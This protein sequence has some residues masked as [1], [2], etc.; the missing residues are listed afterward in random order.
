MDWH[1]NQEEKQRVKL[2]Q[3]L[4]ETPLENSLWSMKDQ[5]YKGKGLTTIETT[6]QI[7]RFACE[8]LGLSL[9]PSPLYPLVGNSDF[10]PG[11]TDDRFRLLKERGLG[12]VTKFIIDGEW[13]RF[14]SLFKDQKFKELGRF[15][16]FQMP[17]PEITTT[18]SVFFL[19]KTTIFKEKCKK[20]E[21]SRHTLSKMYNMLLEVTSGD[22][23]SPTYFDKW[24]NDVKF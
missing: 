18:P 2:E 5:M 3:G 17:F 14:N 19:R 10:P 16:I 12:L 13:R 23:S 21:R 22:V 6:Q 1:R 7:C 11:I 8:K 24:E 15:G 9:F 20:K 4:I